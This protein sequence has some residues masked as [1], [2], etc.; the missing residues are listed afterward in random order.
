MIARKPLSP[1][2]RVLRYA[3]FAAE[4]DVAGNLDMYGRHLG[5]L[6]F[7]SLDVILT[8]TAGT[9]L[10]FL[11]FMFLTYKLVVCICRWRSHRPHVK[12]E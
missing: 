11:L 4:F 9:L 8:L 1:E 12:F 10:A 3:E 7:Y 2:E 5:F 6:A